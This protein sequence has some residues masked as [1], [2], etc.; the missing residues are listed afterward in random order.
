MVPAAKRLF[1]KIHLY[2]KSEKWSIYHT[3]PPGTRATA[4]DLEEIVP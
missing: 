4:W 1:R 2:V 3:N